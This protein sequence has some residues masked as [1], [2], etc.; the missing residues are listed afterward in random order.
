MPS[1]PIWGKVNELMKTQITNYRNLPMNVIFTALQR[2]QVSGDE[3]HGDDQEIFYSPA[4]TPGIAG[5]LEAAVGMIG[6]LHTSQVYAPRKEAEKGKKSKKKRERIS[7]TRL[8][9]GPSDRYLTKDRYGLMVPHIDSPN[10][11]RILKQIY[12]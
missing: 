2:K 12:G 11:T 10:I 9:I 8:I 4:W 5:H 6:Y 7:R 3:D 1:R